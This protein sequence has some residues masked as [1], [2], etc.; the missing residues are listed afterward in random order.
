LAASPG[1]QFLPDDRVIVEPLKI[2]GETLANLEDNLPLFFAGNSRNASDI[3][4]DQELENEAEQY[5]KCW[6]IFTSPNN[7]HGEPRRSARWRLEWLRRFDE[8]ALG[9]QEKT[10]TR[11]RKRP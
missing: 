2:P 4:R 8:Y 1:F 3:L 9:A 7:W 10:P 6:K 5:G 11:W